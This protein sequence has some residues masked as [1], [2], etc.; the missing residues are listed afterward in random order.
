[1]PAAVPGSA[2][3]ASLVAAAVALGLLVAFFWREYRREASQRVS[4]VNQVSHELRTPLTNIRM[5]ADLLESDLERM[6]EDESEQPKGRLKIIA[7]E[8]QRLSR[9]IGNVLTMARQQ[10]SGLTLKPQ[11]A[12][13]DDVIRDVLRQFEPAL[14]RCQV[15]ASFEAGAGESVSVDVDV[16]EQI[17]VNLF[18]NVEK[19]AASGCVLNVASS[20]TVESTAITVS[21]SG[22]GIPDRQRDAIF[23][24]FYLMSDRLVDTAGTG[25]GLSIARELAQLHGGDVQLVD[26]TAGASFEVTL[27]TRNTK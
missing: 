12:I 15:E 1:M 25:I 19:Y 17:L 20:Q 13:V 24:P 23:R 26:S 9:L 16:L 2:R 4:F 21:D 8:S 6:P 18:S 10:R 3:Y 22:P 14:N 7:E 11:S 27:K 5:Y